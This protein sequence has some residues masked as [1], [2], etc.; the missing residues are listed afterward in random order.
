MT[1]QQHIQRKPAATMPANHSHNTFESPEF[2]VHNKANNAP[3][4]QSQQSGNLNAQLNRATRFGHNLSQ[5]SAVQTKAA[6]GQGNQAIQRQAAE[7]EPEQ[8]KADDSAQTASPIQNSTEPVQCFLDDLN[9]LK[10]VGD[11]A[12]GVLGGVAGGVGD[13]LGGMAGDALGGLVGGKKKK[14]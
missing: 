14:G 11:V 4:Q 12:G 6:T 13:A 8:M 10:A 9:P 2:A 5:V 3:S 1:T 7:E